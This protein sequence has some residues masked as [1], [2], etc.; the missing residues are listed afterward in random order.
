MDA[1]EAAQEAATTTARAALA[2]SMVTPSGFS[3]NIEINSTAAAVGVGVGI[4]VGAVSLAAIYFNSE[5][6]GRKIRDAF[7]RAFGG[8]RDDRDVGDINRGSLLID[9]HCHTAE[10]FLQFLEDYESGKVKKDLEE[11][12]LKIE[13]EVED[14]SVKIKNEKEV[15][16]HKKKLR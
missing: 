3:F 5:R 12:L 9:L 8:E 2:C 15:E 11:E 16:E 13:I 4:G 7:E 10:S 14:L 6:I 1:A